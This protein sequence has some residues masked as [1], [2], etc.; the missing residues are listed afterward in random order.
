MSAVT[1]GSSMVRVPARMACG[2]FS[3]IKIEKASSYQKER[4]TT[5]PHLNKIQIRTIQIK[6]RF[7]RFFVLTIRLIIGESGE[8][9]SSRLDSPILNSV[10][11]FGFKDRKKGFKLI[12]ILLIDLT[13]RKAKIK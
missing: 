9:Y 11:T 3:E 12:V 13:I 7:V 4:L 5:A 1:E 10:D 2:S 6:R 8:N